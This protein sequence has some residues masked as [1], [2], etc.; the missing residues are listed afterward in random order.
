[1]SKFNGIMSKGK[2]FAKNIGNVAYPIGLTTA[3]VVA[4]QKFM[5]FKTLFPNVAPDKFFI[6]HEGAIKVGG[7]I[8]TFMMW[9]NMPDY[10]RWLL[11]GVAVQGG[12]KAVRQYTTGSNGK[13]FVDQIGADDEYNAAIQAAANRVKILTEN[14]VGVSGENEVIGVNGMGADP[15]EWFMAAA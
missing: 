5:D 3:G 10:M 13:S 12:I 6:K 4:A 11:I 7:V 2:G 8:V 14:N 9:K 1:M 15:N